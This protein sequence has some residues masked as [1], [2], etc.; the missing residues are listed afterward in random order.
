MKKL[1]LVGLFV[2]GSSVNL[3]ADW[4]T[5]AM[6][7]DH[8]SGSS[9]KTVFI[10]KGKGNDLGQTGRGLAMAAF[11]NAEYAVETERYC[12]S[13]KIWSSSTTVFSHN[14]KSKN[15]KKFSELIKRYK[16]HSWAKKIIIVKNG[17]DES[18]WR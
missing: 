3:M 15:N 2:V 5:G 16:D 8:P 14:S 10:V 7:C 11:L 4:V 17:Y 1:V 13:G 18:D 9:K 6:D 12:K